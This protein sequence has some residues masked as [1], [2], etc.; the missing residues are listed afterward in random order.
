MVTTK[1]ST[2]KASPNKKAAPG[3][4][5]GP[6]II[7]ITVDPRKGARLSI[8]VQPVTTRVKQSGKVEFDP[9]GVRGP[10]DVEPDKR[11]TAGIVIRLKG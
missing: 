1:V 11:A 8:V 9:P 2:K 5:A 3:G 6:K 7:E 4:K 10:S